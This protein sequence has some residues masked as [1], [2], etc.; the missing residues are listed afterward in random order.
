MKNNEE[1][2][3]K[4][5]GYYCLKNEKRNYNNSISN[6]NNSNVNFNRGNGHNSNKWRLNRN[7]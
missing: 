3:N 1:I 7:N 2:K 6:Y 5:K 4:Y